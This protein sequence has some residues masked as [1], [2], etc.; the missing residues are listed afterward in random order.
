M[1]S[2]LEDQ[3]STSARKR[4]ENPREGRR[5]SGRRSSSSSLVSH[6]EAF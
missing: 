3:Q 2:L 4:D 5:L 6:L 1:G